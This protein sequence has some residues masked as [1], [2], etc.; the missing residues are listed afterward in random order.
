[1]RE[2][3]PYGSA[4]GVRSNP[5]PYRDIGEVS[6]ENIQ[7]SVAVVIRDSCSHPRLLAPLFVERYSSHH[8]NIGESSIAIV[9]IKNAGGAVGGYVDIRPAIIV[10]IK[11]GNAERIASCGLVDVSLFGDIREG[12][13][14]AILIQN[15]FRSRQSARSAHH[16]YT[17]PHARTSLA[18]DWSGGRIEIHIICHHQIKVPI[19]VVVNESTARTPGFS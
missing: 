3:R 19:S 13:I 9:V 7:P 5:Y 14:T 1:M 17:L 2:I 18:R 10:K 11:C 15:V 12:P 8:R 6:L 16:R 4:R